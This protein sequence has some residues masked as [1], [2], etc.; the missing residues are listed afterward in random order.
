ML[1]SFI[2]CGR[3]MD[4]LDPWFFCLDPLNNSVLSDYE[5]NSFR[6]FSPGGNLL[7]TIGGEGH[8]PGMFKYPQGVAITPNGRS[9]CV[10]WNYN[11]GIQIFF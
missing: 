3:G 2:A 9:V 8:Q 7:H 4:A 10:S 5:T 11:C 6:V 1:H